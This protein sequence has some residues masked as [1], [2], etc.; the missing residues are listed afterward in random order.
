MEQFFGNIKNREAHKDTR[1]D[2]YFLNDLFPRGIKAMDLDGAVEINGNLLILEHK[3]PGQEIP[4]GQQYLF[5]TLTKTNRK[6]RVIVFW[7]KLDTDGRIEYVEQIN[8]YR[9]GKPEDY[10]EKSQEGIRALV[11]IWVKRVNSI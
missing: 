6:I 11:D 8:Y 4:K 1:V 7:A 2:W 5:E 9:I 10:K 3:Q